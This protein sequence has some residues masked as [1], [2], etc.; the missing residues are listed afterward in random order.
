MLE[1]EKRGKPTVTWV[2]APLKKDALLTARAFGALGFAT[3]VVPR[4]FAPVPPEEIREMV[5]AAFPGVIRGLTEPPEVVPQANPPPGILG[6][7]GQDLLDCWEQMNAAFRKEGWSD[8]LPLVPPTAAAVEGM[9][10]GT[11]LGPEQVIASLEPGFGLATVRAIAVNAVM[12]G[13]HPEHLP[14]LLTAV[15]C[16]AEPGINLRNKAMST[17]PHAP[18]VLVNG[19]IAGEIGLNAKCCALGPGAVSYAN[20]VIGRALRLIMMN[21]GHNYP[22]TSDMDAQGSPLKYSLCAAENEAASPWE[23]YHVE[24]GYAPDDSTVT[25]MFVYGLVDLG[26]ISITAP[27]TLADLYAT[28]VTNAAAVG[29]GLWL[30]THRVDPRY[31]TTEKEHNFFFLSPQEAAKFAGQGW[32]KDTLRQYLFN[33]ARMPLKVLLKDRDPAAI[34]KENPGLAGLADHPET[35]M[36]VVEDPECYEIAVV[37]D[38]VGRGLYFPGGGGPVTRPVIR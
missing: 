36:P 16:L 4:E 5:D 32:Q 12:A 15:Q 23:A 24:K 30:T 27:E 14:V 26:T 17:G 35:L 29:S 11:S 34:V 8:G 33:R 25:V 37:G 21:V 13:C 9:L 22:L 31:Q 18:L 20:T 1:L 3:A 10:G 7:R 38:I 19:P 6:Y 28:A 2:T